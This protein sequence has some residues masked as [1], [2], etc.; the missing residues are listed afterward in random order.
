MAFNFLFRHNE[1]NKN[2]NNRLSNVKSSIDN[3]LVQRL[4]YSTMKLKKDL[5]R[6]NDRQKL[7]VRNE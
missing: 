1:R 7:A 4:K 2:L 3:K 5:S 6:S